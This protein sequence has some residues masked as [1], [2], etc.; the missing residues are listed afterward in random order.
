M[1]FRRLSER[2]VVECGDVEDLPVAN[3]FVGFYVNAND[4]AD[5]FSH[6][7]TNPNEEE[8]QR[9]FCYA[10]LCVLSDVLAV[11]AA[12]SGKHGEHISDDLLDIVARLL[13]S[14]SRLYLRRARTGW[15]A[16]G[17]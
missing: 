1:L 14:G 17:R 9:L 16:I 4:F 5:A 6:F 12:R 2:L 10:N 7:P 13:F 8:Q 15:S 11:Q 3:Q